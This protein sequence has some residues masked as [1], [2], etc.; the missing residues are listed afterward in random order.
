MIRV[1]QIGTF[2]GIRAALP[3]LRRAGGGSIVNMS[4]VDGMR[5]SMNQVAYNSS[6]FAVRGITKSAAVELGHD[7]IRV[8]SVHPGGIDTPMVRG[9]GLENFDLDRLF[10]KIPLARAG[11]P[12]EVGRVVAFLVSDDSAP[13]TLVYRRFAFVGSS[14]RSCSKPTPWMPLIVGCPNVGGPGE[15]GGDAWACGPASAT[16]STATAT[17]TQSAEAVWR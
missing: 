17:P 9:Q 3:A 12:E 15:G 2:L 5:G 7:K 10:R 4:S 6:K 13:G 1:N 16:A 11:Q 14:R 8:N